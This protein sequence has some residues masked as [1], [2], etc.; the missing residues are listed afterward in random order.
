[1]D[2]PDTFIIPAELIRKENQLKI[3]QILLFPLLGAVSE[4]QPAIIA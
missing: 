3:L 2:S 1:M 4:L